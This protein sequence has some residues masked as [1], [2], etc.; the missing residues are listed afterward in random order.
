MHLHLVEK[1][2]DFFEMIVHI[3]V[4]VSPSHKDILK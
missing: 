3:D 1:M 2:A 4:M